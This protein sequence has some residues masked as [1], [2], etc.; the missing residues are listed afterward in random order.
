AYSRNGLAADRWAYFAK[1][2]NIVV[3]EVMSNR[4]LFSESDWQRLSPFLH[5]PID[6]SVMRHLALLDPAFPCV[7]RLK[8]M[9][10]AQYFELQTAARRLAATRGCLPIWFEDAW[11]TDVTPNRP[12]QRTAGNGRR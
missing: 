12:M 8:H 4:E 10:R 1:L 11:V 5:L 9:T 7:A 3:Y 6:S 2:I